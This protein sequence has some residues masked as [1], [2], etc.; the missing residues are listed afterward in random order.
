MSHISVRD[1]WVEFERPGATEALTAL[2]A[3]TLDL[4]ERRGEFVSIVGPSG[5]G[6]S[7]L[8]GVAAGLV[9]ATAGE[10]VIDGRAVTGPGPDRAVVFQ[11]IALLP[12]R[13]VL[14]NV[15][16]GMEFRRVPP[17][18]RRRIAQEHIR[19]V[20]LAGFEHHYPHHLSGG[21]RQRVGIARAL[22]VNPDI[23]LMDEPFG[24]L[25]AQTRLLMGD[26]LL[27]IWEQT[28]KSVLFVTHDLEEAIFLSDRVVVL[29]ARP[30]RVKANLPIGLPRP[31]TSEIRNS[32]EFLG[33]R[34]ALWALLEEEALRTMAEAG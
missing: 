5:C 28:R 1:L 29:T 21:M 10:V 14:D 20:G 24:A 22:A 32:V 25:D 7:T 26:E 3:F 19:L 6:K 8:L 33:Y 2:S 34:K 16:F 31:R 4:I 23:L 12:W 30:G 13:T 11:E 27:R 17:A 18:E 9:P 15:G